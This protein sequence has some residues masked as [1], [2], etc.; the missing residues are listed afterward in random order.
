MGSEFTLE[1]IIAD[2]AGYCFGVKKAMETV[3]DLIDKNET[4]KTLGPIIHNP[5]V[6]EKLKSLG[7]VPAELSEINSGNVIV[8]THGVGPGLLKQL[9]KNRNLNIINCTCPFVERVHKLAQEISNKEYLTIIIGDHNHPEVEG[10]KGWCNDN[11]KII[12]NVEETNNFYTNKKVGIVVQTTQTE[13]NVEKIV[14]ILK[15]KLDVV[16]FHD[17]RCSYFIKRQN[18]AIAV[19]SDVM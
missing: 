19:A 1:V 5:Q 8:R 6:V 11:V 12:E 18:A 7:I 9:K 15:S 14:D 3:G 16:V 4:A 17:T 2:Y 10:I 13:E